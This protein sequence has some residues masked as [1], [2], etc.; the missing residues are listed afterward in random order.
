MCSSENC[1]EK[2][3]FAGHIPDH[4]GGATEE[5]AIRCT[6]CQYEIEAQLVNATSCDC[7][8]HTENAFLQFIWK[9]VNFFS[10]LFGINPVCSCGDKHY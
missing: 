2:K 4:Q 7:L 9:I 8:C 6:V 5:Y 3:D 10:K 1:T